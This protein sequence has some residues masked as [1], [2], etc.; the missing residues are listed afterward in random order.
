MP[1]V[2]T[3]RHL[4]FKDDNGND[5]PDW[6]IKKLGDVCEIIGGGTPETS[7]DEYWNGNI[8]WFT[9]TEIKSNFVSKSQRTIT[10]AGLKKSSAKILPKG[11][12]LLTTR[13]TIGEAAIALEECTTNQG[14]QSLV[15]KESIN[16]IYLF[17]WIKVN[18]YELM[19]RANGSTFPEISK[20]EI[21]QIII[22]VPCLE[23]QKKI[24]DF[25]SAIDEKIE[26]LQK[27]LDELKAYK[28][29]VMQAIFNEDN[30][31]IAMGGGKSLIVNQLRELRFKDDNENEFPAW[32]KKKLGEIA[33][34]SKG[35]GI[36]KSDITD[37]GKIECIRYGELYTHYEEVI[38]EIKSRTNFENAILSEANDVIIPA[39]GETQIDIAKASC[40]LKSGVALGG[41]LNIIKSNNNGVFLSYY[42]NNKKK[43]DIASLAQG[44][45]VV[46]LYA[47]QLA[48]LDVEIPCI[49]EQNKI[50]D[51]LTIIDEKINYCKIEIDNSK[52]Y[53]KG[54]LQTMFY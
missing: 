2:N 17:N 54:V 53:K 36:S 47:S 41:D 29:G 10:E 40:V 37:D 8:Q 25:L 32:E 14:F 23:E 26:N 48:L 34:F 39:S 3:P 4:R 20:S 22:P 24:A 33:K 44:I 50:A 19:K 1:K 30:T 18:R 12:I 6:E 27:E 15:A 43:Q 31:H 9:P 51:F 38:F 16:N 52:E 11:A 5:Y 42:L 35:K 45:S 7:N 13:A 28:K 49:E 21:E 46:H